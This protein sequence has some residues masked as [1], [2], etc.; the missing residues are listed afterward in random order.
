MND[1]IAPRR[2]DEN[3]IVQKS[4]PL[5]NAKDGEYTV[6]QLKLLDTYLACVNSHNPDN[7]VIAFSLNEYAGITDVDKIKFKDAE[8][9]LDL[10]GDI[11]VQIYDDVRYKT[12]MI[13]LFSKLATQID[14][15]T[16]EWIIYLKCNEE[17][18]PYFFN[19]EEKTY[20]SYRLGNII[21]MKSKHSIHLYQ[22]LKDNAFRVK[23]ETPLDVVK[24]LAFHVES[25]M[26]QKDF[27]KFRN[28]I[29]DKAIE[30]VNLKTDIHVEYKAITSKGKVIAIEF[31]V[32]DRNKKRKP[33]VAKANTKKITA[34]KK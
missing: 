30:E 10:L 8:R 31:T 28:K 15:K 17:A 4:R 34:D 6:N 9:C 27:S 5:L 33:R 19:I 20:V 2:L 14:D 25:D 29:L 3:H 23:W 7:D 12:V 11:K 24:E 21:L 22:Y 18:K 26:Y 16:G 13:P 1:N 32:T